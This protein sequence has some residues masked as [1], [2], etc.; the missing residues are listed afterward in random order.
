M[1]RKAAYPFLFTL[2]MGMLLALVAAL[3]ILISGGSEF[4]LKGRL[5]TAYSAG[6]ALLL[7]LLLLP[8][9]M[10][11]ADWIPLLGIP[12]FSLKNISEKSYTLSVDFYDGLVHLRPGQ[13][14]R[15]LWAIIAVSAAIKIANAWFYYGFISGDDVEIHEMTLAR[16]FQR[17][18]PIWEIRNAFYPMVFIYPVQALL[19]SLGCQD[20]QVLVF[21][22]RLVVMLFSSFSIYLVFK[23]GAETGGSIQIGLLAAFFLG[24]S[25]LHVTFGGS[26]LP[27]TVATTFILLSFWFLIK[28]G[29]NPTR[30]CWAGIS[31][32]IAAA[33]R[34]SELIF[35]LPAAIFLLSGKRWRD[36]VIMVFFFVSTFLLILGISDWLYWKKAF[37]SLINI[38][39]FTLMKKLSTRGYQPFF[40]YLSDFSKWISIFMVIMVFYSIK[41][42]KWRILVWPLLPL[43]LLSLL[44][45]KEPRYLI[46]IIP[47]MAVLTAIAALHLLKAVAEDKALVQSGKIHKLTALLLF[48]F[49]VSMLFEMDGFRFR[50]SETAVDIARYL[51][52]HPPRGVAALEDIWHFGG[53]IYL[54]DIANVRDV[55]STD[56][57]RPEYVANLLHQE[58][59]EYVAMQHR[60]IMRN[61]YEALFEQSGFREIFAGSRKEYGRFRLF[62]K[63][64][65]DLTIGGHIL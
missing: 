16:I 3:L 6:N 32:G 56:L 63:G 15:I 20:P 12:A 59:I 55:S 22:G 14:W 28:G 23:V 43:G 30:A 25:K 57:A 29:I 24:F 33:V 26:E 50:R 2:D 37:F 11:L 13:A 36:T 8:L 58:N 10:L 19:K 42:K 39:D 31:L 27:R 9:R 62:K 38:V 5:V 34:F 60:T 54:D 65:E 40:Y 47:F 44:P 21:A 1:K 46:P 7:I 45:H 51:A 61:G 48:V 52:A 64:P 49:A 53:K 35:I 41:M 18:W 4:Q 17:R